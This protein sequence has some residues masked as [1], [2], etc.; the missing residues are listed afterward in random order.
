MLHYHRTG[1]A[2]TKVLSCKNSDNERVTLPAIPCTARVKA[3][4]AVPEQSRQGKKLR[5]RDLTTHPPLRLQVQE[6]VAMSRFLRRAAAAVAAALWTSYRP[7]P[8]SGIFLA[9]T[10]PSAAGHLGLFFLFFERFGCYG[11]PGHL[12]LVRARPGLRELNALLAPEALLL[13]ATHTLVAAAL[14]LGPAA[15]D[16]VVVASRR[17]TETIVDAADG[18]FDDALGALTRIAAEHP[19][20]PAPR[21]QAAA[22]CYLL[23]R[24]DEGDR[25]LAEIPEDVRRRRLRD[26]F[27]FQLAVVAAA[28]GGAPGAVAGSEDRVASAALEMFNMTLWARVFDGDMSV[29]KKMLI[30]G[31]LN[32]VVKGKYKELV[33]KRTGVHHKNDLDLDPS[34]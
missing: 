1:S 12:G 14:R 9:S 34:I 29:Y 33:L 15:A 16:T 32:L 13:D 17:L 20:D 11:E 5:S 26:G 19:E 28:L 8:F 6:T 25:W 18:R 2:V 24:A 4:D 3:E 22:L 30:S 21:L 10:G 23:G 27:D 7:R 31:L